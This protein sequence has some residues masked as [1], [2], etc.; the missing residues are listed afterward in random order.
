VK[1]GRTVALFALLGVAA[2][3]PAPVARLDPPAKPGSMAPNLSLDGDA[4]LLSWLEP[5]HPRVKPQDGNYA[6]R[7]SRFMDGRWSPPVTIA[8]GTD[9]FANWADFP[10]VTAARGGQ[11]LAHW[12][13]KS[14]GEKYAYDVRLARSGDG[15][16][17]WK[18]MGA[19]H[20]DRTPTEHGFVSAVAEGDRIR[21]FW[22]DG[23]ETGGGKGSMTLRTALVGETVQGSQLL[24]ARVCDCCQTAAVT[25]SRGAVVAYRDR[26]G[27]EIRDIALVRRDGGRW[28]MPRAVHDDGWTIDGCPVNGPA[29]AADGRRVAVAWFTQEGNRPR[30]QVAFSQDAAASF[31]PPST[32]DANGPLGR[33]D[34][35]LDSNGDALIAWVATE[36]KGAAIRLARVT[37]T[38]RVGPA[39]TIASTEGGRTSGFPRLK[40]TGG[41]LVVAW[42]EAS[43]PF[44]LRAATVTAAAIPP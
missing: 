13:A 37:F 19:A 6:L 8:S 35:V 24:D 15:G 33:V 27:R 16:R 28:T 10:S 36:G 25:T 22:L 30:V 38:G 1:L 29:I 26:S 20:D 7:L 14:A 9:F 44:R 4:V 21:L 18:P 39:L 42:V 34:V 3:A 41:T 12:A 43:E 11:M 5:P 32:V 31:R 2:G 40:R 23:R 17:T